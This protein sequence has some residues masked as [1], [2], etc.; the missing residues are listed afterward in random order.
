VPELV[1]GFSLHAHTVVDAG[2]VWLGD[3]GLRKNVMSAQMRY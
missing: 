2:D 3:D 1:D